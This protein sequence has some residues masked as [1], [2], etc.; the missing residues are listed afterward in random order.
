MPSFKALMAQN[1]LQFY[2]RD[3][4]TNYAQSR[5][6]LYYL[7]QRGLLRR[8]YH[9]F[10]RAQRTDPTGYKT[11]QAVL[12]SAMGRFEQRWEAFVLGLRLDR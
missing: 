2:E 7:Q 10:R 5:Y 3:P 9:R 8:F 4:G 1:E 11:L 6:L 12:G